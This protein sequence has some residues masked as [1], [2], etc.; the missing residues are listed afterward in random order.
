MF[1]F[2]DA[3]KTMID[4]QIRTNDVTDLRV[5]KA[6]RTVARE[7][8]VPKSR[9]ALAYGDAHV[10]LDDGR[11]LVRPREFSKMVQAADIQ[12]SDVVLDIACGRGYSTAILS[13]LAETVVALEDTEERVTRATNELLEAGVTNAAVLQGSLKSGASEHGPFN[14]IFVN[15]AVDGVPKSWF[16]QLA[17]GGR[18]VAVI[19]DGPV[20]RAC[21]FTR[22]GDAIGER[23][24]CDANVPMMDGF[25]RTPAFE[26]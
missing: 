26:F 25:E 19:Q 24:V 17:H 2:S 13:Q 5:L 16:D 9:Q 15:G 14:V 10:D 6:F 8:F 7:N 21:I 23:I 11:H 18:L 1:N 3:R 4:S 22:S 12:P 20:G